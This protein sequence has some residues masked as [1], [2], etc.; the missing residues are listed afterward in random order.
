MMANRSGNSCLTYRLRRAGRSFEPARS[1]VMPNMTK[2][3]GASATRSFF[4]IILLT[5][6]GSSIAEDSR[7]LFLQPF[8]P[9]FPHRIKEMR[10]KNARKD[11]DSGERPEK[12][13]N[14]L[15]YVGNPSL[16][17]RRSQF[18]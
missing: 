2:M 11:D 4:A 3:V 8:S 5:A 6:M 13:V 17:A 9:V 15:H 12:D 7:R 16:K 1:P 18:Y 14:I 10:H